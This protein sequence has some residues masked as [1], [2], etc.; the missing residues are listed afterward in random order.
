MNDLT[1][2]DPA[3][4]SAEADAAPAPATILGM[5]EADQ[6]PSSP[7][8]DVV[9]DADAFISEADF[10][11]LVGG[12]QPNTAEQTMQEPSTALAS[13]PKKKKKRGKRGPQGKNVPFKG[14]S[15]YD[16]KVGSYKFCQ[17]TASVMLMCSSLYAQQRSR[18]GE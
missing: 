8:H 15:R 1:N 6:A 16:S 18:A 5:F 3:P 2:T 17:I 4:A 9:A 10:N 12:D 7:S 11:A 13:A 14:V